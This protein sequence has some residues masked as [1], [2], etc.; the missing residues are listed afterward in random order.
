ME[1][2]RKLKVQVQGVHKGKMSFLTFDSA[3]PLKFNAD[4]VLVIVNGATHS[5]LSFSGNKKLD[6]SVA[7]D[8]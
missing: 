5:H 6:R 2:A 4:L 1:Q 8:F 3:K 7:M